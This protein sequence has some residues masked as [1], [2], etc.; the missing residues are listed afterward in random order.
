MFNIRLFCFCQKKMYI[1]YCLIN[2][3]MY[4][5]KLSLLFLSIIGGVSAQSLEE[6]KKIISSYDHYKVES[7]KKE[8]EKE[9][10]IK[11]TRINDYLQKNQI[12]SQN[13]TKGDVNYRIVDVIDG[14]P[15]LEQTFNRNSGRAIKVNHLY[16]GGSLGLSLEG[17]GMNIAIWDGGWVLASH[18]EFNNTGSPRVTYGDA[19]VPNPI[20]DLHGTHV[21]GTVVA[22]GV[23]ASAKGMAPKANL[24]S[25]NWDNDNFEV[26]F[27]AGEGLLISNHS[28]G[29]PIYN[30]A[31]SLNV[32]DWYM[33]CYNSTAREWDQILYNHPYYLMVASAGNSGT[34]SYTGGLASGYDKLTGNK[35]SKNNLVVANANPTVNPITGV[36]TSLAI[37]PGSSQGP[38]DDGRIKPD[39]A[40]DGTGVSS[41]S[42]AGI[43]EYETLSGTSMSSPSTAGALLLLQEHYNN[44]YSEYMRA[45]TLKGLVCHTAFDDAQIGPDPIFGWGLLDV[46]ES[47]IVLTNSAASTP[48]AIVDERTLDQGDSYSFQVVVNSPKKLTASISWTDPAGLTQNGQLN[49]SIPALVNDLDIRI[50]KDTEINYP[51]KLQLSDISAAAIKGDNIVDN[52]ER[53]D[54]DDAV[55]TYTIQVTHKGT[56]VEGPQNYSL[57]VSGFDSSSLS[58]E[59]FK[60]DNLFVYPNPASDML[61]FDTTGDILLNK[62]EIYDTIGKRILSS[63][64]N[65]NSV[66]ISQLNSGVYFVKIYSGESQI[67][68]KIIKK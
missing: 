13:F 57:I 62:V 40:A 2:K 55:G 61:Y 68:K 33:G 37:N 39:I 14:N 36:L 43:S 59:F 49:S 34:E 6:R 46:R 48:T 8:L 24:I 63:Q 19:A 7:F 51:W 41:T 67:T 3:Y 18:N 53:V 17:E 38:S 11:Q 27:Q 52:F 9:Y 29:V 4:K 54:I 60:A 50:I 56:L 25:Y 31:G 65:N 26:I 44:I 42:N 66:D 1:C 12:I 35:N 16:P 22:G 21:A 15:V 47:A 5:I 23:N 32:P 28:Y 64:V 30:D 45:A 20:T 10:S 58:N